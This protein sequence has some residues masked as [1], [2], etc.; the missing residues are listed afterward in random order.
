M[1]KVILKKPAQLTG[2]V[3]KVSDKTMNIRFNTCEATSEELAVW[4][5]FAGFT[6][7]LAFSLDTIQEEDIP[8]EDTENVNKLTDSQMLRRKIW[9]LWDK[10]GRPG[11]F[12]S[13]KRDYW[14]NRFHKEV[15]R[16][17]SEY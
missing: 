5:E 12:E 2:V 11:E 7:H 14:Y 1:E 8:I 4:D 9:V 13:Y 3:R 10:K 15:D 6:G 17:L 16:E